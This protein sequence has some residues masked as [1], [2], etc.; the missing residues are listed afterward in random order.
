SGGVILTAFF[1][2][3]NQNSISPLSLQR[4]IT[5]LV[6]SS[7]SVIKANINP[8]PLI[9]LINGC[10]NNSL[11]SFSFSSVL[12]IKSLSKTSLSVARLAAAITGFPPKVVICPNRGLSDKQSIIS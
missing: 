3:N 11:K 7:V 5:W 6:I 9:S 12:G 1:S 8:L 2:N 10:T 4:K